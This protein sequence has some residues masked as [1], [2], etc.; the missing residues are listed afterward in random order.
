MAEMTAV[1]K[2]KVADLEKSVKVANYLA[3]DL[4]DWRPILA[5]ECQVY[6]YD[7]N[8]LAK[9]FDQINYKFCAQKEAKEIL[10]DNLYALLRYKYFPKASD[11]TEERIA[12]IV[13]SFTRNIKT[14]LIKI[15]FDNETDG[16]RVY[17]LADSQV[18]FRNGVFDFKTNSWLFKYKIITL[19]SLSNKIYSYDKKY[20]I[21]WYFN[22]NFEP[23]DISVN[24]FSLEEFIEFIKEIN[25]DEENY[26]FELLYNM[27]FD[28]NHKFSLKRF[29]HM[30]EILGYTLLQSFSQYFVMLIGAGQ[31]GKNSLFDGC[32]SNR[33]IP[34]V[35]ANSLDDIEND[36]FIVG[37]LENK[38]HNIF[39]E[40][41]AKTYTESKMIKALTGSMLQ[42]AEHKGIDKYSTIVNCKYIFA[43]NDQEKIK[44]G[45]TTNGFRRRINIFEIYYTYDKEKRFLKKG[46][47]FDTTFSDSLKELKDN[48]A[49][50][51]IYIYFAI[52]GIISG[53]K[54]FTRNFEFTENDW[55]L[56]YSDIDFSLKD[57]LEEVT[58][59]KITKFINVN[60][61]N[62]DNCKILFYDYN[63]TLLYK[64]DTIHKLGIFDYQS[65]VSKLLMDEEA[66]TNYF[67]ENDVYINIGLL[68]SIIKYTGSGISFNQALKK[69]YNITDFK[70]LA[71][72]QAYVKVQILNGKLKILGGA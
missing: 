60:E 15:G 6:V 61:N 7:E 72:N 39:L 67:A 21:H 2:G 19:P 26:C 9:R 12:D 27:S 1:E 63:E 22:F 32:F 65:M 71:N 49:N 30:C 13:N 69:I 5:D 56:S 20:I 51:I 3:L 59:D 37:S 50:T 58:M 46:E 25:K 18:A 11:E 45:D 41:S 52:Y 35:A 34:R 47:Y 17:D 54:G 36:R 70:R 29:K 16:V 40:T 68:R 53:T 43:G 10:I 44:F 24:D 28:E 23:L 42:F 64:S 55:K 57:A 4:V 8:Y 38:A 48:V 66:C 14:S 62:F 31:N 33:V